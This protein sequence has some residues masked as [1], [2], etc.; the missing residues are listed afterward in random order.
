MSA[1]P[2]DFSREV[3]TYLESDC[4]GLTMRT[5]YVDITMP[6]E[7]QTRRREICNEPCGPWLQFEER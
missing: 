3:K 7:Q 4:R 5:A 2:L 6:Q 1:H